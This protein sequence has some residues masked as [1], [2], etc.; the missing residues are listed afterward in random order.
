MGGT[1]CVPARWDYRMPIPIATLSMS[2]DL[3]PSPLDVIDH[4]SR[5]RIERGGG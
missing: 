4:R 5:P 2:I 3:R 1:E